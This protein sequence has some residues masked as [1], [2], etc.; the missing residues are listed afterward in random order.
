MKATPREELLDAFWAGDGERF[1]RQLAQIL[2]NSISFHDD[3]HEDFY[4][5]VLGGLFIGCGY[6]VESNHEVG[7]R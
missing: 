3:H 6:D 1:T 4:H 7:Y 5:A 2:L